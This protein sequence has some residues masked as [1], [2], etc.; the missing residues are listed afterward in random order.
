MLHERRCR[1]RTS[2]DGDAERARPARS[3]ARTGSA[4]HDQ[5]NLGAGSHAG[6]HLLR[7]RRLSHSAP[8]RDRVRGGAGQLRGSG[9]RG[10]DVPRPRHQRRRGVRRPHI[11]RAH[12]HATR[13]ADRRSRARGG[14]RA[15]RGTRSGR[16]GSPPGR[17]HRAAPRPGARAGADG[18]RLVGRAVLAAR[19]GR[20]AVWHEQPGRA[21]W[22]RCLYRR[23]LPGVDA[24][25]TGR[26]GAR[27]RWARVAPD[28]G[29]DHRLH[30]R[31]PADHRSGNSGNADHSGRHRR[32]RGRCRDDVGASCGARR[33]RRGAHRHLRRGRRV[34]AGT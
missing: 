14:G 3:V 21:A 28:L 22:R 25:A 29:R 8:Q 7:G 26:A 10:R 24:P 23:A 11:G 5:P 19:G 6:R 31:P 20:S 27:D 18:V 4:G 16:R 9:A 17:S 30:A 1:G 34:R 12:Q 15:G 2:A 33:R 32:Q 13:R